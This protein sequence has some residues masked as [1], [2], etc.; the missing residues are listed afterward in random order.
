[1]DGCFAPW[2]RRGHPMFRHFGVT[3]GFPHILFLREEYRFFKAFLT[4][5]RRTAAASEQKKSSRGAVLR[6]PSARP[7]RRR[8]SGAEE[9]REKSKG[10]VREGFIAE[11]P[12]N[13]TVYSESAQ[14][15]NTTAEQPRNFKQISPGS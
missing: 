13:F 9:K 2:G 7:T 5:W 12:G 1:M 14:D 3:R 10:G 4:L 6:P 8:L 11:Q 15:F